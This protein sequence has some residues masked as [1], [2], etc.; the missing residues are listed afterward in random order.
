MIEDDDVWIE[1]EPRTVSWG[2]E[3]T[4][5]IGRRRCSW[6]KTPTPDPTDDV[7]VAFAKNERRDRRTIWPFNDEQW[8]PGHFIPPGWRERGDHGGLKLCPPCA[9]AHDAAVA[10]AR[11]ACAR[12]APPGGGA[13]ARFTIPCYPESGVSFDDPRHPRHAFAEG[14]DDAGHPR[15]DFDRLRRSFEN[16][17]GK[18]YVVHAE[19]RAVVVRGK[20][21]ELVF[22]METS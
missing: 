20:G 7:L 21:G 1:P 17:L 19:P 4:V 22:K 11:A 10:Q 3:A 6:C 5:A 9:E 14:W 2:T 18:G 15:F 13:P 12:D 16:L 8:G